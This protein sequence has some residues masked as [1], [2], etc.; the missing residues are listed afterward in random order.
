[1][2]AKKMVSWLSLVFLFSSVSIL[3]EG[4]SEDGRARSMDQVETLFTDP[5]VEYRS[6]PFWSW[7]DKMTKEEIKGSSPIQPQTQI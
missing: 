1:M 6:A 4:V 2:S 5:P 3:A 7:N